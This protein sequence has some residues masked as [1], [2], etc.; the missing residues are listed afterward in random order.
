MVNSD[1]LQ[2][3]NTQLNRLLQFIILCSLTLIFAYSASA[4]DNIIRKGFDFG[5]SFGYGYAK[6]TRN[7]LDASTT[8]YSWGLQ[9]GYG[10]SNHIIVGFELGGLTFMA[11][12][13]DDFWYKGLAV[14]KMNNFAFFLTLFP[15]HSTPL[16]ITGG[17]GDGWYSN[18]NKYDKY[19]EDEGSWFLGGGYEFPINKNFTYG[20]QFRYSRGK[21]QGGEFSVAEVSIV[22]HCYFH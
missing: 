8:S 2:K 5:L 15:F 4:E 6:Y 1:L 17:A 7:N 9:G 21:M 19:E 18:E 10:I 3:K 22:C 20:P 12:N 13:W 16:Y 14:E 11:N